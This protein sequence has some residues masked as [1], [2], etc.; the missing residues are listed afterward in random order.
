[1]PRSFR[2]RRLSPLDRLLTEL[3]AQRDA[4]VRHFEALDTKAG[5]LLADRSRPP[6]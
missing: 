2:V 3:R 6:V 4:S 1:M 5:I